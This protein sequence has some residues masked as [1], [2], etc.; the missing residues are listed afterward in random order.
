MIPH[1][2]EET[3]HNYLRRHFNKV[4]QSEAQRLAEQTLVAETGTATPVATGD[5]YEDHAESS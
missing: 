2:P 1:K 5:Y 3:L 4:S